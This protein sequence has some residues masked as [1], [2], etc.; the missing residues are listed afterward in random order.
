M[1]RFGMHPKSPEHITILPNG[2]ERGWYELWALLSLAP[3][4]RPEVSTN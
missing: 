2:R 1:D 4:T 3:Q